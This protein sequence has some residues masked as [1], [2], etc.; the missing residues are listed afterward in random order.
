MMR[1]QQNKH[2]VGITPGYSFYLFLT[3]AIL[4]CCLQLDFWSCGVTIM[5]AK[6][7][8]VVCHY[9]VYVLDAWTHNLST[10]EGIASARVA[11]D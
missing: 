2:W 11:C 3:N 9:C 1:I 8:L 5:E 10:Q 7:G 4:V 6:S